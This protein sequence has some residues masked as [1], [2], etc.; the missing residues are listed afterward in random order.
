MSMPAAAPTQPRF[1]ADQLLRANSR[2]HAHAREITLVVAGVALV[3]LLAKIS[4]F[5]GPVPITGQSLGVLIVG[6]ALGAKRGATALGTYLAIGLAGLPVFAGPIAGPAY[7]AAP[8]FGFIIG[9]VPAAFVAGW[10]AE[11]QWDRSPLR[12]LVGFS[13][14]SVIPF[15]FGL[16]Y[17]AIVL[18]TVSGI[19]VT[20]SLILTTGVLP[21]ILPGV[22]KAILAA[23][24]IPS[25]WAATRVITKR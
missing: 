9:F 5:I 7:L 1:F 12:A 2:G 20:P 3:A 19:E 23:A 15:V 21:F 17:M 11:R 22:I 18:A 4:F 13:T 24:A 6:A 25:A 16:P 8:S 14:A 10:F